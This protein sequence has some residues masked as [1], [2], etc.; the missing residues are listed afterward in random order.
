MGVSSL[1]GTT[2]ALIA[3]CAVLLATAASCWLLARRLASERAER[4]ATQRVLDLFS[5]VARDYGFW[6]LGPEGRIRRWSRGAER[7]HGYDSEQMLGRHCSNLYSEA[8]RNANLPQQVL[9][10]AARQGRHEFHGERAR[11]DGAAVAVHS[12]LQSL[13]DASGNLTGFCEVEHDLTEQRQFEQTL[14]QTRSALMQ[15]HKLEA[16]GR[17]SGGVA[18]DFNNVVQVIKNCVRVLQRRL[19]DQPQQLQ[20][21]DMIE[22]NADRAAGLSHHLLGFA[23]PEPPRSGPTNVHEVVED[24]LQLLRQTLNESIVLASVLKSS[25]PWSSIDRTQLEAAVLNLA[26]NARDAMAGAGELSIATADARLESS[27]GSADA[28]EPYITIAIAHSGR[29]PLST[30][31]PALPD[32]SMQQVRQL[33][34]EAGGRLSVESR[35]R[36]GGA[37]VTLWLPC[38]RVPSAQESR[39]VAD[40]EPD[41]VA[42]PPAPIPVA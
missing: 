36:G 25:F 10:L 29:R 22:R 41:R 9:E 1:S 20:F 32:A 24:A 23:R 15:A 35:A 26:A 8:D 19:A 16:L 2:W 38:A 34:E 27:P 30:Q 18:H 28:A 4:L 7:I 11:Q 42:R 17:L 6:L 31:S 39:R 5:D 37:V 21:L 33:I 12:V 13:R 3:L 14:R 40:P